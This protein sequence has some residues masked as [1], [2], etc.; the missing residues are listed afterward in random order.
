MRLG[1]TIYDALAFDRGWLAD[2]DQRLPGHRA[3][4]AA[5]TLA[6]QPELPADGL[7]GALRYYDCQ[8]FSPERLALECLVSAAAAGASLANYVRVDGLVR[9]GD[10]V[11]GVHVRDELTGRAAE[12]RAGLVINAAG[13]WADELSELFQPRRWRW[14]ARRGST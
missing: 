7:V 5:E 14:S 10:R 8:M 2:P 12:L 1:L 13:P 11:V 3:L 4:T 9:E 6:L